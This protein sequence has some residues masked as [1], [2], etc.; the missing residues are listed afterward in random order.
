MDIQVLTQA[1]F[2]LNRC[3]RPEPPRVDLSA[4]YLYK[5]F[6][7]QQV[8]PAAT[9]QPTQTVTIEITGEVPWCL[10]ALQITGA[11]TTALNIQVLKP[12]GRFLIN[13]LQDVL[14]IAGYGSYRFLFT[15]ELQCEPGSKIQVTL[16]VTNATLQQPI[17]MLFEGAYLYA[18]KSGLPR[19][20]CPVTESASQ[21][22]RYF[23]NPSQNI[24][25]P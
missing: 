7:V 5:G 19:T 14:Q 24:M 1:D 16:Q 17:A 15:H 23:G 13:T 25:A 22:P 20:H 12:D 21:L 4:I 9:S 11:V 10:R 3:G 18:V 6:L 2:T 8:F